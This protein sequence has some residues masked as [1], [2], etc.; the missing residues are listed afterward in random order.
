MVAVAARYADE[1]DEAD[2]ALDDRPP[3]HSFV[4]N[5]SSSVAGYGSGTSTN[6]DSSE[7]GMDVS[8]ET[9]EASSAGAGSS[10][11][12][13][14]RTSNTDDGTVEGD[15]DSLSLPA[16]TTPG[17]S[18][19]SSSASYASQQDKHQSAYRVEVESLVRRVVPD[20]IDNIDAIME[21]FSGREEELIETLRVMQEKSIAQRARAAVQRSAKREAGKAS[22]D[23][24]NGD[25]DED[26][27][28]SVTTDGSQSYSTDGESMSTDGRTVYSGSEGLSREES[29]TERSTK[30]DDD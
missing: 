27:D 6:D 15:A 21:Q 25:D 10:R 2:E 26:M 19:S 14:T 8:A 3:R 22:R 12:S 7:S 24:A 30:I 13:S 16:T 20:E 11:D 17:S 28:Q 9:E 18:A 1:A 23:T 4:R 5:G 29:S